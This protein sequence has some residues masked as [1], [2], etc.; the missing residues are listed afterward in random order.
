MRPGSKTSKR[1]LLTVLAFGAIVAVGC[2]QEPKS[3]EASPSP[4]ASA[5][6]RAEPGVPQARRVT[7]P[8]T[9]T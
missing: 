9:I 2:K 6:T 1:L 4:E 7:A 8:V 3:T 5:V